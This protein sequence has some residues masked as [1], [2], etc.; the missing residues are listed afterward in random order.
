[1]SS[2]DFSK[3]TIITP[4]SSV[5]NAFHKI[6]DKI[7]I[8]NVKNRLRDLCSPS[9]IDMKRWSFELIQN[10]KDSI[11]N[12]PN[13]NSI[14]ISVTATDDFVEFK[15]NGSP[16]TP[17]A[18]FGLIYKYSDGKENAESTGRFGTGFL[19]THSLSKIVE[20]KGNLYHDKN[21]E[22][23][24]GFAVTLYREGEHNS[25]LIA[26]V[27]KMRKSLTYYDESYGHT[28]FKYILKSEANI[29]AMKKG[30]KSLIQ[31][32]AQIMLFCEEIDNST[33]TDHEELIEITRLEKTELS[34]NIYQTDFKFVNSKTNMSKIRRFIHISHSREDKYLSRKYKTDRNIRLEIAIEVDEEKNIIDFQD[35]VPSH[36]CVLPLIGSEKHLMPILINSPDFEPDSERKGLILDSNDFC[37]ETGIISE[38]GINKKIL[39]ET[40]PLFENLVSFLCKDYNNLFLLTKG[41]QTVPEGLEKF[42]KK[43]FENYIIIPYRKVLQKYPIV[44][45]E[46]GN[47]KLF[48]H[49]NHQFI[50]FPFVHDPWEFDFYD[51]VSHIYP[52][53]HLPIKSLNSI[54]I[55]RIWKQYDLLTLE[56]FCKYI[57]GH[58]EVKNFNLCEASNLDVYQWFNIFFSFVQKVDERLLSK[59][60][61]IPN[62]N[63]KFIN[64]KTDKIADGRD[65][66]DFM[67]NCLKEL[68]EDLNP[69][70][71]DNQITALNL[72]VKLTENDFVSKIDQRIKIITSQS[73]QYS[74][75]ILKV[76]KESIPLL[77]IVC[78]D[79]KKYTQSFLDK[80]QTL[81]YFC[82]TLFNIQFQDVVNNDLPESCWTRIHSYIAEKLLLRVN[83]AKNIESLQV[84]GDKFFW[85]N[86]FLDFILKDKQ[87][88]EDKH[89]II[90]DQ[91]GNF[92]KISELSKD[93]L[94]EIFKS[95][96]FHVFELNLSIKLLHPKITLNIPVKFSPESV[97]HSINN[98]ISSIL[99]QKSKPPMNISLILSKIKPIVLII[100]D[101]ES[102]YDSNFIEK[103]KTMHY[104]VSTLFQISE[105]P[106]TNN[107]ISAIAWSSYHSLFIN[108]IIVQVAEAKS[109]QNLKLNI[110]GTKVEWLNKFIS[111]ILK[112][113]KEGQLDEAQF[114]ILPDQN[115]NF[116][117][118]KELYHDLLPDIFKSP[119]FV[120]FG[121]NLSNILLH[122]AITSISLS[123]SVDSQNI[124]EL[125]NKSFQKTLDKYKSDPN[126][127]SLII[128]KVLPLVLITPDD[129]KQYNPNFIEKQKNLNYFIS[130]LL[131]ISE[132]LVINN[133][134]PESAWNLFHSW[135]VDKLILQ[136]A[137]AKSIRNLN[138][139]I[140][141]NKIEW[142]NK[143]I[144]FILKEIK[145]GQLDEDQFAILLDQNGTFHVK[146]KLS[147]DGLPQIFKSPSFGKLGIRLSDRLLHQEITSIQIPQTI[148]SEQIAKEINQLIFNILIKQDDSVNNVEVFL[149][150]IKSIIL[151]TPN[152]QSKYSIKFINRQKNLNF[153]TVTFFHIRGSNTINNDIP[154]IAWK[155]FHSWIYQKLLLR[156]VEAKC[157][158]SLNIEVDKFDWLNKFYDIILEN[159]KEGQ[160][161]DKLYSIFPDQNENFHI[162]KDLSKDI[163]P[164]IFKSKEF[165]IFQLHLRDKLL[166]PRI[167]VI[168]LEE[169]IDSDQ[170][171]SNINNQISIILQ[172]EKKDLSNVPHILQKIKEILQIT[173]D[174]KS[175]YSEDFIK[176]QQNIFIFAKNLFQ[177]H[178]SPNVNNDIPY[179][180]WE[181][182]HKWI[183]D[184]F[185][186]KVASAKSINSLEVVGDKFTFLNNFYE[187]VLKEVEDN[188]FQKHE[189]AIFPDQNED[190]HLKSE[191]SKD[192]VPN[193][194]KSPD[195]ESYGK[196]LTKKL[197]HQKITTVPLHSSIDISN[198]TDLIQSIYQ[199][200]D[201]DYQ[202][203]VAKY[204][205]LTE[206]QFKKERESSKWKLSLFLIR[207]L[208]DQSSDIYQRNCVLLEF[209]KIFF[210][211]Y[212]SNNES[213]QEQIDNSELWEKAVKIVFDKLIEKIESLKSLSK[214]SEYFNGDEQKAINKL[215]EFIAFCENFGFSYLQKSIFPIING[216]FKTIFSLND[217]SKLPNRLIECFNTLLKHDK[218]LTESLIH[219]DIRMKQNIPSPNLNLLCSKIDQQ[220]LYMFKI[221]PN[222]KN[223]TL[224]YWFNYILTE[225]IEK[226]EEQAKNLFPQAYENKMKILFNVFWS[227]ELKELLTKFNKIP[228]EK[229]LKIQEKYSLTKEEHQ[230]RRKQKLISKV[231]QNPITIVSYISK[232]IDV[233]LTG[234]INA[235]EII[236]LKEY[237]QSFLSPIENINIVYQGIIFVYKNLLQLREFK[238]IICPI[239]S[240]NPTDISFDDYEGERFYIQKSN[241]NYDILIEMMDGKLIFF[242]VKSSLEP[243]NK[244]DNNSLL[245]DSISD[246]LVQQSKEKE[247][248]CFAQVF[249][250]S[251]QQPKVLYL[252]YPYDLNQILNILKL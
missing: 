95:R 74:Y 207:I 184:K 112:E 44:K 126:F 195:F 102:I 110:E 245:I 176:K 108:Y 209:A 97:S 81:K 217:T 228:V 77:S 243:M 47:Q 191:L 27:E 173:P 180:A 113:I 208:P 96:E 174:N 210:K 120:H 84:P 167:T 2:F 63:S 235:N 241:E 202:S 128:Q 78:N 86:Q 220:I 13:Q 179:L 103:Q 143:F 91:T 203:N 71:I 145:E 119:M 56:G 38:S 157:I 216:N 39:Q 196:H 62:K 52:S 125:I 186:L 170:V 3:L 107:D 98:Y 252:M 188:K 117:L 142:L 19:T 54:W 87:F 226:D 165:D 149:G 238:S 147:F 230:E 40:I 187:F 160:L 124:A 136:V 197:L 7:Y 234:M 193:I 48:D 158:K 111:F 12:D 192:E 132:E 146:N 129:E 251:S 250:I 64:L 29:L 22:A 139:N 156:V 155:S 177:F 42:D 57:K 53:S 151:I 244:F 225:W 35:E 246:K 240:S 8:S 206:E 175:K 41:L 152:D 141:G 82:S 162:R 72:P 161:D 135:I 159:V 153:L 94:P 106:I 6:F 248:Y 33:I 144:S 215:N 92:R 70:L 100:P 212:L 221:N 115:E 24:K 189:Y 25:E 88:N 79:Q 154:E 93:I 105:E 75:K 178:H 34:N 214:F 198:I 123:K 104:F 200:F 83:N 190:F 171:A 89:L 249:D 201:T 219:P 134:I 76:L 45:T 231:Q 242:Q 11:A 223:I 166:H 121:W 127:L 18:M 169:K 236:K 36:F 163:L 80:Q 46:A 205:H 122:P 133:D 26:G 218:T 247:S 58:K 181:S 118:K 9:E 37:E 20:I 213:A 10:A 204:Q 138:L 116:H 65:F 17:E 194:F 199:K 61:M 4:P 130:T 14:S 5:S 148:D 49:P 227:Q 232:W 211:E 30:M 28:M 172:N 114:A 90:P 60:S 59:Y 239:L 73:D 183:I 140:E 222:P 150:K 229:L 85:L 164:S 16:F 131:Q 185:I 137:G 1:M 68:G 67:V 182:L 66:T 233:T 32:I 50:I 224:K 15:H 101:D 99:S 237:Y 109:I 69:F 51:I 55:S 43:W 21:F 31:N 168:S 23:T